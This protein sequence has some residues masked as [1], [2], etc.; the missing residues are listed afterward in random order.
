MPKLHLILI[1]L[2][3]MVAIAAASSPR[4][5]MS[6]WQ[7]RPNEIVVLD[8]RQTF[9]GHVTRQ[10]DTITVELPST[11]R[12]V[13]PKSKVLFV[14]KT[15]AAAYWELAARTR[16]S[17][18]SGQIEVFQ[19]CLNHHQFNEASNHLLM[20][21]E[22]DIPA[23]KLMQLDVSLQITQK[24]F[25]ASQAAAAAADTLAPR[26]AP[27]PALRSSPRLRGA[28]ASLAGLQSVDSINIPDLKSGLSSLP[29]ENRVSPTGSPSPLHI[30]R[31]NDA[32]IGSVA[33]FRRLPTSVELPTS[34]VPANASASHTV[35]TIDQY[36][37][38]VDSM[39]QQVSF[40]QTLS[41]TAQSVAAGDLNKSDDSIR[42]II[43]G[44][45]NNQSPHAISRQPDLPKADS[46]LKRRL[47]STDTLVYSDLDRLTR[48]MPKGSVGLF[49]TQ[50]EPLLQRSCRQCHRTASDGVDVGV[51]FEIHQAV[52]GSINRRMS[53]KNLF[54]A[55]NLSDPRE[56]EKSLLIRYAT[57][58]HG[59]QRRASFDL[60]AP[61]LT[62][63]KQWLI[64][65]SENPF[66][67]IEKFSS[68]DSRSVG[69]L[70]TLPADSPSAIAQPTGLEIVAETAIKAP[71]ADAGRALGK[72]TLASPPTAR[73]S[74]RFP[75][76]TGSR[77][78][79]GDSHEDTP[80]PQ[81]PFEGEIFNRK[82]LSP[83]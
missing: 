57:T 40:D 58:A 47:Q 23:R 77:G 20:L 72:T 3:A 35:T 66:L 67:P 21:Q 60:A 8:N 69:M 18:L 71:D 44:R 45:P 83:H 17:D 48:S 24:R 38:E 56:P 37:N 28:P 1:C 13:F 46:R 31:P 27:D 36:G 82:Y 11:S 14:E 64:M 62:S 53:Q 32:Q 15:L 65:I 43:E 10:P 68:A 49:R 73:S 34:P 39:V 81:D 22:M 80:P 5:A 33:A 42:H 25:L 76:K 61:Q 26:G 41:D 4:R 59:N 7:G 29:Q 78:V 75:D 54:Q 19:W 79:T 55:L 9:T 70:E 74:S 30:P 52:N 12:L 6:A 16:S 50:V 63:L 2:S 51:A